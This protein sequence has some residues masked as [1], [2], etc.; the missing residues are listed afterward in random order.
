M[1]GIV[2]KGFVVD[3]D[4]RIWDQIRSDCGVGFRFRLMMGEILGICF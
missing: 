3:S 4:F 1:V 2:S